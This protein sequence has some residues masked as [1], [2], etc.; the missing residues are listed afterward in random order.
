VSGSLRIIWDNT[1]P[2]DVATVLFNG[3]KVTQ[4]VNP[5]LAYLIPPQWTEAVE[6]ARAHGL[7]CERLTRR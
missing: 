3:S 5:P 4:T 2:M 7:R 6:L 1:R